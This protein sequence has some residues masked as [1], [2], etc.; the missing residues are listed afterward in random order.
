MAIL[1]TMNS[2]KTKTE[3]AGGD[4]EALIEHQSYLPSHRRTTESPQADRSSRLDGSTSHCTREGS[5]GTDDGLR[6]SETCFLDAVFR[7]T[8]PGRYAAGVGT[9]VTDPPDVREPAST[10]VVTEQ[11]RGVGR[12]Q[13]ADRALF[14]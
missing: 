1:K 3:H 4:S 11:V 8:E 14:H 7:Q 6:L 10:D 2:P 5:P 12:S 9:S 13:G